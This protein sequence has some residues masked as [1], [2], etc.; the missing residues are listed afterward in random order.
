MAAGAAHKH[1]DAGEVIAVIRRILAE[2]GRDYFWQYAFAGLCL[3]VVALSTA[4]MAWIMRDVVDQVFAERQ[5]DMIFWI[6]SAIVVAFFLRGMASYG[7]AVV[8]AG[9][10]NNLVARYQ[11]RLFDHLMRLGV[12]FFTATRSGQLTARIS[13]NVLGIRDLL[14]MTLTAIARDA[15]SLVALVGV[16]IVQDPVLSLIALVIGPPIIFSVNYL[17][18]RLRRATREAVEV[19]ARLIGAMQES[20]QG[21]TI[22]KAFTME[23][24]LAD[25]IGALIDN[26]E[27]RANRIARVSERMTPVTEIL[28]GLAIAGVIAYAGYRAAVEQQPPGAVISFVTAL[29]LAYEPAKRLA[30]VQVNL[31]RALVNARMIYEILDLKPQQRDRPDAAELHVA[32]GD[33]RFADLSFGYAEDLPVLRDVSFRAR[34]GRT[35][36]I[37]GGS[38]AGKS[39]LVALLQRFYDPTGGHIE[40][41]GQDIAGVTKQSLRNSIAY[42]SQQPHLFEGSIRDNIRYGRPDATDAE[43]EAAA[44]LAQAEDFIRQQPEGW[45]TLVGENG[46]TLSGG[47]RQRLSIA[48]AILRDAPILLL[49]EATSALDNESE[50]KVQQALDTVMRGR[51][52]LVIA[53]RLSTVV[54]ADHIVVLEEGRLIEE[55][56]HAELVARNGVYARFH[57]LQG[58]RA[59]TLVGNEPVSKKRR[60]AASGGAS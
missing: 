41:D 38:G 12:G 33:V 26:A 44:K 9:I 48:R 10:G 20:M 59:P 51:T 4:F 14:S 5:S 54:N 55:G 43:V 50:A 56:T 37:V 36:A 24:L 27:I 46:A 53:H 39:T 1:A 17:M 22:V 42:V 15:T 16:M 8:L 18:R 58:Q 11:K 2:N 60:R 7:Q 21:I 35:T 30:R 28:A 34:A 31:E 40:I 49:D 29:L 57:F 45:D 13:Q 3:A 47:Q 25:K 23:R 19:N 52:T 6:C 32:E